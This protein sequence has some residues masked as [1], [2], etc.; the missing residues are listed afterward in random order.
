MSKLIHYSGPNGTILLPSGYTRL[1]YIECTGSQWFSTGLQSSATISVNMELTFSSLFSWNMMFGNWSTMCI[2]N[3]G[4]NLYIKGTAVKACE[5]N[6]KYNIYVPAGTTAYIDS[7]IATTV[8]ANGSG[9]YMIVGACSSSE[10]AGYSWN[11]FGKGKIYKLS[12]WDN[13]TLVRNYVPAK[14][15]DGTVGLLDLVD[16]S[17]HTSSTSTAFIAGPEVPQGFPTGQYCQVEWLG[18]DT[19]HKVW[20]S[21]ITIDNNTTCTIEGIIDDYTDNAAEL[22]SCGYDWYLFAINKF[23]YKNSS[24]TRTDIS[25]S[26]LAPGSK[27]TVVINNNSNQ[28]VVDGSSITTFSNG[29][30]TSPS[31]IF[32]GLGT[33]NNFSVKGKLYRVTTVN[34]SNG[35]KIHDLVPCYRRSDIMPG[36]YDLVAR[37]FKEAP[38][39]LLG[40]SITFGWGMVQNAGSATGRNLLE[41]KANSVGKRCDEETIINIP[42]S[43]NDDSCTWNSIQKV[44]KGGIFT[45]S[46]DAKA[47]AT[48]NAYCYFYNNTSGLVQ[49]V[50]KRVDGGAWVGAGPDG[51]HTFSITTSWVRHTIS[52]QFG[53]T[54]T[55]AF[56]NLIVCRSAGNS[57][58]A[59]KKIYV[60]NVKLQ[61]G[62]VYPG[63]FTSLHAIPHNIS[64][65]DGRFEKNTA[66]NF[67]HANKPDIQIPEFTMNLQNFTVAGW[68]KFTAV[69]SYER[70]CD[71]Q[72]LLNSTGTSS[73]NGD[74]FL[75]CRSGSGNNIEF[76]TYSSGSD[77]LITGGNAAT[78]NVWVHLAM[79][80]KNGTTMTAYVNGVYSGTKTRSAMSA[81]ATLKYNWLGR[82]NWVNDY[83]L[84][85]LIQDFQLFD[86]C[87]EAEDIPSLM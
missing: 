50:Q 3:N 35:T 64:S 68:I 9:K 41:G 57:T 34:K 17:W 86:H 59:N 62:E 21:G 78:S 15:S 6:H 46:F 45:L 13:G 47:D 7:K 54:G 61:Y 36:F 52:W 18:N 23:T 73:G 63:S 37:E 67:V 56:K 85:G 22:V 14:K 65:G 71:F 66:F 80:V 8:A 20:D 77:A 28:V 87:V 55:D 27:H 49:V 19:Y 69:G 33:N 82:S 53:S 51:N 24:G 26:R 76:H 42:A 2:A 25:S 44:G 5:I 40:P 75:I 31:M 29:I 16:N 74:G 43:G 48:N 58:N 10:N 72:S 32:F 60:R 84:T 70:L 11:G 12:I 39:F 79:T 1:V 30:A 38:G 81:N 83:Y 4:T